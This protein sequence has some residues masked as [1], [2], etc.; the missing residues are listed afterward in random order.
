MKTRALLIGVMAIGLLFSCGEGARD[1][2]GFIVRSGS[3]PLDQ[4]SFNYYEGKGGFVI[5]DYRGDDPE[6]FIPGEITYDGITAPVVEIGKYAFAKRKNLR[7]MYLS[8]S[9]RIISEYAF[10]ESTLT[11]LYTTPYLFYIDET[12]FDGSNLTTRV[13]DGV[14]YLPGR[15]GLYGYAV[16]FEGSDTAEIDLPDE[17]EA[18]Y[19][20]VFKGKQ[21]IKVGASMLTF[22]SIPSS[23]QYKFKT[24]KNEFLKVGDNA[25]LNKQ[26]LDLARITGP[27]TTIGDCAFAGS[28]VSEVI[29]PDTISVIGKEAF[30]DCQY[31]LKFSC[32]RT[33][34]PPE[35]RAARTGVIGD[36]AFENCSSLYEAHIPSFVSSF[37]GPTIFYECNALEHLYYQFYTV[38][39]F[40][41]L[42]GKDTYGANVHLLNRDGTE[43]TEITIPASVEDIS[44]YAFACC[45]SLTSITIPKTVKTIGN[46]AFW[47]CAGL[48]SLD[49]GETVESIGNYAFCY[50][51]KLTSIV[52]P[53]SVV[54]LG[55]HPFMYSNTLAHITMPACYLRELARGNESSISH[56]GVAFE[57]TGVTELTLT[58][59]AGSNN[60]IPEYGLRNNEK[61]TKVTLEEGV[62]AIGS[63]AF[64]DCKKLSSINI[65]RSCTKIKY[66]AFFY[67][68]LRTIF[69]PDTVTGIG[70]QAFQGCYGLTIYCEASKKPEGWNSDWKG[71]GPTVVWGATEEQATQAS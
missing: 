53:R 59:C 60:E 62:T 69:I 27:Y 66:R 14:H 38:E 54:S 50:C 29:V 22:G 67:C 35:S 40:F 5:E 10:Y 41:T 65:P 52:I 32:T 44:D 2:S 8:E 47:S 26:S 20:Y 55:V 1:E 39:D 17:C 25:F 64:T 43:I 42:R 3:T 48:T 71:S 7:N 12:A 45:S 63:E 37:G 36:L 34:L 57:A 56:G 28:S 21:V 70:F 23:V 16:S 31:L 19:D 9:V 6:V 30:K 24:Y 68:P 61:L 18:V 11:E 49:L 15:R 33:H 13:K 58:P 51:E 4:F 46:F